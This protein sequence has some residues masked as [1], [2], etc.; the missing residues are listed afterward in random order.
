MHCYAFV[1]ASMCMYSWL[2][3]FEIFRKKKN[4]DRGVGGWVGGVYRIQTFF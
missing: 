4:W 2:V 3:T 1:L